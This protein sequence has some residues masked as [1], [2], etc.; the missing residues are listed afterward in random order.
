MTRA[1]P[2]TYDNA[3]AK[4]QEVWDGIVE[5]RG[6]SLVNDDGTLLGPFNAMVSSPE[7]G[8]RMAALGQAIRFGSAVENRLLELAII[9]VGAHWRSN[10]EWWAHSGLAV[11]AGIDTSVVESIAAGE[12]PTFAKEDEAIVYEFASALV[13]TGRVDQERFEAAKNLLGEPAIIDLV[14]TIGYYCMISLTLNGFDI[15][16]PAG[17]EPTWSYD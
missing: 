14:S 11:E 16:L 5:S 15:R 3:T 8:G 9:V 13:G 10:F 17:A 1:T 6:A 12:T 4:Q 2:I 7:I